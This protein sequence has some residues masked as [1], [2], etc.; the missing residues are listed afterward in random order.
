[1]SN[2]SC[3]LCSD[4][5]CQRCQIM[6]LSGCVLDPIHVVPT[7]IR[8]KITNLCDLSIPGFIVVPA[9]FCCTPASPDF[10][11]PMHCSRNGVIWAAAVLAPTLTI[12]AA[13]MSQKAPPAEAEFLKAEANR[14]RAELKHLLQVCACARSDQTRHDVDHFF[15]LLSPLYLHRMKPRKRF[16]QKLFRLKGKILIFG[17]SQRRRLKL[18]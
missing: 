6:R 15:S 11:L 9:F 17:L 12:C 16:L 13:T 5:S 1:M 18:L 7:G 2:S 3:R 10:S 8:L 4:C 14:H